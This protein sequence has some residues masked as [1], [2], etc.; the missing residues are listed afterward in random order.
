VRLRSSPGS[1]AP[2]LRQG[3]GLAMAGGAH[4][5]LM[6]C[7]LFVISVVVEKA[8]WRAPEGSL[9]YRVGAR[10]C[11]VVLP[12]V[13]RPTFTGV[14]WA[15]GGMVQRC[16][17]H[18]GGSGV[19]AAGA[20][21]TT[22]CWEEGRVSRAL[23]RETSTGRM[24]TPTRLA[25]DVRAGE[26]GRS[27]VPPMRLRACGWVVVLGTAGVGVRLLAEGRWCLLLQATTQEV[28]CPLVGAGAAGEV[29]LLAL[30]CPFG[31]PRACACSSAAQAGGIED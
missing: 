17:A 10:R 14:C 24:H 4:L 29:W 16:G 20:G 30:Q 21:G 25:S 26:G 15:P 5:L 9:L 19:M 6:L 18:E 22:G 8:G 3:P 2:A 28:V 12:I 13:C 31:S 11:G 7:V 27:H 23:R 1:G